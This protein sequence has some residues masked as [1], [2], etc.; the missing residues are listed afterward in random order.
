MAA[1]DKN[2]DYSDLI[3]AEAAKG[4]NADRALLAELEAARNAKIAGEGLDYAQT[5]VYTQEFSSPRTTTPPR[6][7]AT[8]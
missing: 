2:L 8:T 6:T 5:N 4:V 7:T 1:Y 3:A